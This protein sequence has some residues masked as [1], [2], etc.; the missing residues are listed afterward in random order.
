[1]RKLAITS[2]L[3]GAAVAT[4][5]AHVTIGPAESTL[6]AN[7]RYV[8]RVPTE[9]QVATVGVD[10]MV[11]EGVTVSGVLASS[12]WTAD[13]RREG[14]RTV[15]I[16]WKVQIPPRQ[17]GELV[18]T[19]RNPREGA[20]IAWRVVQRF[21]DGTSREWT[22]KTT[23]L[24]GEQTSV[25][26]RAFAEYERVH[27]ALAVDSLDGLAAAAGRLQA[28]AAELAGE[29]AGKA[30]ASLAQAT[31][32]D[33]ARTRLAALSEILVPRF[34]GANIPGLKGFVCTMKKAQWV[35]RGDSVANPYYG[36]AMPTCGVPIKVGG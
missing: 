27:A 32:L 20:D 12:G 13:N 10:L 15:S 8:V 30:A 17:F 14:N 33:Q 5:A 23:L 22:P 29:P 28:L 31:T 11:P 36:K 19:A 21:E 6:G 18:F 24:A 3:V 35:Q 1:M 7:E 26:E 25:A 2:A 4:L 34:M 16:H 9:G